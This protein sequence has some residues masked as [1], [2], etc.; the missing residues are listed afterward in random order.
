MVPG[1]SLWTMADLCAFLKIPPATARKWIFYRRIPVVRI[2]RL[3]RFR[4]AAIESWLQ[5]Q[6][7]PARGAR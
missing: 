2:G 5:S 4:P 7:S 6:T 3:I 1:G